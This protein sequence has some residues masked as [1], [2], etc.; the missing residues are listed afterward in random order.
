MAFGDQPLDGWERQD[1]SWVP[2]VKQPPDLGTERWIEWTKWSSM[3]PFNTYLLSTFYVSGTGLGARDTTMNKTDGSLP[4]W[5]LEYWGR[6]IARSEW[7]NPSQWSAFTEHLLW[8]R[9]FPPGWPD[10]VRSMIIPILEKRKMRPGKLA[11]YPSSWQVVKPRFS[12]Q[13]SAAE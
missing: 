6:G 1:Q 10:G 7:T 2:A 5:S 11:H 3:N 13:Q 4:S 8:V 12:P 9:L